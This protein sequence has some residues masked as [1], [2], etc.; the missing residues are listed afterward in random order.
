MKEPMSDEEVRNRLE[1][2]DR[3]NAY[4]AR[5]TDEKGKPLTQHIVG[6]NE[7]WNIMTREWGVDPA[8]FGFTKPPERD[9]NKPAAIVTVATHDL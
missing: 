6:D 4:F 5:E 2:M 3:Y 9:T 1:G 7:R 8:R